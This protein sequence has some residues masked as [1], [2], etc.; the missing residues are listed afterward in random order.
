MYHTFS[1]CP[2]VTSNHAM[3]GFTERSAFCGIFDA[4]MHHLWELVVRPPSVH[5]TDKTYYPQALVNREST[6][7]H[8]TRRPLVLNKPVDPKNQPALSS[9]FTDPPKA[10]RKLW[11]TFHNFWVASLERFTGSA[12]Q[13][14]WHA[15]LL[16]IDAV[17]FRVPCAVEKGSMAGSE[18]T[19]TKKR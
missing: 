14:R 12:K 5:I 17:E 2:R 7:T 11:D 1:A 9:I 16:D 10:P 18:G 19:Q 8:D 4:Y 13:K 15:S 3:S 6:K